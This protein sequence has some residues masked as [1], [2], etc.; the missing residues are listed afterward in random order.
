MACCGGRAAQLWLTGC[1]APA[2][3]ATDRLIASRLIRSR[4]SH[5]VLDHTRPHRQSRMCSA[6]AAHD[7]INTTHL[8][9]CVARHT[10]THHTA[11]LLCS[12]ECAPLIWERKGREGSRSSNSAAQPQPCPRDSTM[13]A[14]PGRCDANR[15][16][17]SLFPFFSFSFVST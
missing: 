4:A 9:Y 3:G 1:P 15:T 8:S 13:R 6:C 2:G 7:N 16:R 5:L 12:V 17:V 14:K 11:F 10:R